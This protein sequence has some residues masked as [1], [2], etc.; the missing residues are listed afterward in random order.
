MWNTILSVIM[1][2]LSNKQN[3]EQGGIKYIK[4]GASLDTGFQPSQ[5]AQ[6]KG[7]GNVNT[8]PADYYKSPQ[9]QTNTTQSKAGGFDKSALTSAIMSMAINQMGN[10]QNNVQPI[11]K[12]Q[13]SF[14]PQE[15]KPIGSYN[16]N[17]SFQPYNSQ[18]ELYKAYL[19]QNGYI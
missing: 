11:T 19:R 2:L 12:T 10:Q 16:Q 6:I 9:A 15:Q 8:A 5:T 18:D 14:S 13:F 7:M 17:N 4:K 1:G 3:Q